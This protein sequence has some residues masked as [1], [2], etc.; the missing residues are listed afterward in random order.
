MRSRILIT[1]ANGYLGSACVSKLARVTTNEVVAVWHAKRDRLME[2]QPSHVHY[3]LCDLTN[4]SDVEHLFREL[5]IDTVVHTAALLPESS[6]EYF[7]RATLSNIVATENLVDCAA[8]FGCTRFV[9]CSSISIYGDTPLPDGGWKESQPVKPSSVYGWSKY[10]GEEC[11]RIRSAEGGLSAVSLRL[12]GIHG[13]GRE[14]GIV[15]HAMRAALAN[16][17]IELTA[18]ETPFQFLFV[19]DAV[20]GILAAISVPLN[21]A[22]RPINVASHTYPG[23]SAVAEHIVG[24]CDS[25]SRVSA[26]AAPSSAPQIMNTRR[27]TE[28]LG[29]SPASIDASLQE[30][31]DWMTVSASAHE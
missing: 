24:Y 1:G 8:T 3:V 6:S 30:M 28:E 22:Y 21:N 7:H 25:T 4:R 12:A 10:T 5:E 20:Q 11:V 31:R 17:P 27:M 26:V 23:L 18:G 14:T 13:P 19:G 9:Y 16:Q 15:F 29:L 2:G